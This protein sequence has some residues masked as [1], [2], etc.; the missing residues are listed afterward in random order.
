MGFTAA[1]ADTCS[2][3]HNCSDDLDSA[4]RGRMEIRRFKMMAGGVANY[5][6]IAKK[7]SRCLPDGGNEEDDDEVQ[8][9]DSGGVTGGVVG[10]SKSKFKLE[11]QSSQ[12]NMGRDSQTRLVRSV[13]TPSVAMQSLF[14]AYSAEKRVG[15]SLIKVTT[16]KESTYECQE[17][18]PERGVATKQV[19]TDKL[20]FC[21]NSV[22]AA[23]VIK[24]KMSRTTTTTTTTTLSRAKSSENLNIL[25]RDS[26][27]PHGMMSIIGRRSEMEDTVAAVPS[28]YSHL[29]YHSLDDNSQ[30][31]SLCAFHFFGVYD[32]H[33][34]SQA[35]AFCRQRFHE[36]LAEELRAL[37]AAHAAAC[38]GE[39]RR[40]G[41]EWETVFKS[42]FKRVDMEVGGICPSGNCSDGMDDT[43]D[44]N[45]CYSRCCQGLIAP[46]NV[47]STAVV[48]VLSPSQIVVAN[49]GDSRAVLS[50][51]GKAIPFSNDHKPERAD[52]MARIEAAGGRVIYWNGYRVGG[53]LAMSRA[54]G[55]RFLKQYVISEPEVTSTDRT[56]EDE[57][58]ILATDG[59]WDVLSNDF[60]CEVARK[61]LA[62]YRPRRSKGITE[63]C[64]A[65]AVAAALLTKLALKRGSNDNISVIVVDL[66]PNPNPSPT[67]TLRHRQK[68]KQKQQKQ[69][70]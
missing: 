38:Q 65:G 16:I 41:G 67:P 5:L 1:A 56:D 12:D 10:D 11:G 49:C 27:P 25:L 18:E 24:P 30:N 57:C 64:S 51:G 54:I 45:S 66:S 20:A 33:G 34:G 4:N 60:V 9:R 19:E 28:F 58:L 17:I 8:D 55:D 61:C 39:C 13:S 14:S 23:S 48:A 31:R 44:D 46:E 63:G 59:L 6:D 21:C 15:S 50:R 42:C 7:R 62:G 52:E 32:G 43:T 35:S 68:Q 37:P 47:G 22:E 3:N 36:V 29:P 2:V 70:K 40:D 69:Q 53:F 26:C